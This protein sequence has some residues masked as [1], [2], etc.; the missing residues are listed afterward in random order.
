MLHHVARLAE[1]WTMDIRRYAN[2]TAR[3]AD[4]RRTILADHPHRL[5]KP[6]QIKVPCRLTFASHGR[7]PKFSTIPS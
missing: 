7:Y 6:K 1:R 3:Q 4:Q 5:T 2:F